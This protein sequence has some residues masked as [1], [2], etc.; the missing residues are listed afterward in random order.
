V[1]SVCDATAHNNNNHWFVCSMGVELKRQL[2]DSKCRPSG[3]A[4]TL[5]KMCSALH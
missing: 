5:N 3:S 1:F 4:S 2:V